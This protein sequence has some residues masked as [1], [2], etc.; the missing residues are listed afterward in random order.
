VLFGVR[1][2]RFDLS[3]WAF[4]FPNVGLTV[5]TIHIGKAMESKAIGWVCSVA[6][7]LIVAAWFVII[8]MNIYAVWNR[9]LLWP[10]M[11]E[12]MEDIEGHPAEQALGNRHRSDLE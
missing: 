12:D 4:I 2:M 7:C 11:D 8:G 1:Q 5:A 9:E 3:W 10:G 6:T